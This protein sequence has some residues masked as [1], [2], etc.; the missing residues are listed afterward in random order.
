MKSEG[1]FCAV[2]LVPLVTLFTIPLDTLFSFRRE[3]LCR[4]TCTFS[5][6]IHYTFSY[7]IQF[8]FKISFLIRK[9]L[10]LNEI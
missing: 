8:Q 10:N 5:Y 3:V 1:K 9:K 6:I 4:S 7:I 2:R